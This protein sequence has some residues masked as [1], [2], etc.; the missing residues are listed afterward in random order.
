MPY[1]SFLLFMV[2]LACVASMVQNGL[3][4]NAIALLNTICAALLASS[5]WEPLAD[6]LDKWQPAYTYLWDFIAIWGIFAISLGVMRAVTDAL[7]KVKVRFRKPIDKFGGIF[8]A[9]WTG[10]VMVCFTAMT[11]HTAPLARNFLFGS[12]QPTPEDRMLFGAAPD[13]TWLGFVQKMSLT[14]L[15]RSPVVPFD[16]RAEYILKYGERRA[17]YEKELL[18]L[19]NPANAKK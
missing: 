12:F 9:V 19:V 10:W 18:T 4:G 11:L 2:L 14:S 3:W 7:S 8:F 15:G 17:R 6:K 5:L 1:V 13:H 16:P